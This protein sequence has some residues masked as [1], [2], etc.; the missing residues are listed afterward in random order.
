M[1]VFSLLLSAA[2]LFGIPLAAFNYLEVTSFPRSVVRRIDR[3]TTKEGKYEIQS[4]IGHFGR[5]HPRT[6]R[7]RADSPSLMKT[8][9]Y[10]R[11]VEEV[12]KFIKQTPAEIQVAELE[13][14]DSSP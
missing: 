14:K 6:A 12:V 7:F 9:N 11:S 8:A 1:P 5:S 2:A 3:W 4:E 10:F 13:E